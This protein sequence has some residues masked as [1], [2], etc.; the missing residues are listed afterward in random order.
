MD[1]LLARYPFLEAARDAVRD[2]APPIDELL[3][4]GSR[5]AALDRAI[6]RI[7]HALTGE[8]VGEVHTD[9]EVEVLSYPL[10]RIVVSLLDDNRVTRR[11]A[12]AEARTAA[13][14]FRNDLEAEHPPANAID[15]QRLLDEFHL[16]VIEID[17]DLTVDILR[18]LELIT[19]LDDQRWRLVNRVVDHGRVTIVEDE[20]YI[21]LEAAVQQRVQEGFPLEVPGRLADA[22]QDA[23]EAIEERLGR[24]QL[25]TEFDRIDPSLFP[26]C[27][28][29]LLERVERGESLSSRSR[30]ALAS[31]L[32]S[33]G[34]APADLDA[35]I[36]ADIP[37]DLHTMAEA[38]VGEEG[39][40]QF[41]P[42]SCETMV[43]YGDC[44]NPDE[45]CDRIDNPLAYYEA[46]LAEAD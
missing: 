25:P 14:R 26:P 5:S 4:T 30:F 20:L 39:P 12:A 1:A 28:E 35:V 15:R 11:F 2:E 18:Y 36:E 41:P 44:I 19:Q 40:T 45:L 42:G 27:M 33:I 22:L 32:T 3:Q 8:T 46:A 43:A 13:I 10:A 9:H 23:T 21:L 6:E 7:E 17:R 16:R 38:A 29:A 24:T 37:E 34:L 31:F